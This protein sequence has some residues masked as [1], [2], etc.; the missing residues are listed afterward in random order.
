MKVPVQDT[1]QTMHYNCIKENQK[2][3]DVKFRWLNFC[4][5]ISFLELS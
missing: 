3:N 1:I 5:I 4:I 2:A